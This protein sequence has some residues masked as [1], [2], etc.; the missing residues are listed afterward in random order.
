MNGWAKPEPNKKVGF[1]WITN[2]HECEGKE[3]GNY[4]RVSA[5]KSDA[6]CSSESVVTTFGALIPYKP[7]GEKAVI[8]LSTLASSRYPAGGQT[9]I[10]QVKIF[11][12]S[13][14][15]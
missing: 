15:T 13:I 7:N 10:Y 12:F 4:T 6:Q 1:N 5:Q 9:L 8:K 11:K 2:F 14:F 3:S